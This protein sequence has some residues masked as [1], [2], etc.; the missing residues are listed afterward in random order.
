M[1]P[2]ALAPGFFASE[3][4]PFPNEAAARDGIAKSLSENSRCHGGI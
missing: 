4:D 3:E 2:G 1:G